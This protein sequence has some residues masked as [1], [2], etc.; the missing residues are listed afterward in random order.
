MT[1]PTPLR[2]RLR[3]PVEPFPHQ[4]EALAVSWRKRAFGLLMDPGLGKT[5]VILDTVSLLYDGGHIRG[6]F[7]LAP[8]DVQDQWVREQIP[9]HLSKHIL[10][11]CLVWDA[12][13]HVP[14]MERE[15]K[16]ICTP[17]AG[18]LHVFAMN[19][20]ALSTKRGYN[21][22]KRF[23][24]AHPSMFALDES[25]EFRTP[26]NKRTRMLGWLEDY[27]F[28]KRIMTGTLSGGTPWPLYS[29][30][31][32]LDKRILQCD[33]YLAFKHRYA[34]WADNVS[35]SK[36]V[37]KKTGKR[38]IVHYE[39]LMEYKQLEELNQRIAP[40]VYSKKKED[41][42]GL[43]PKLYE[44]VPT[45]LS[46]PQ[47]EVY[48]GLFE[49]GLVLLDRHQ[50]GQAINPAKLEQLE[51]TDLLER[52]QSPT[53]RMSYR[54]KLT[55]WLR[56]QQATAGIVKDDAGNISVIDGNWLCNPRMR[57][58][59]RWVEQALTANSGR[60]KVIVWAHYRPVLEAL[61]QCLHPLAPH[62]L[63]HGGTTGAK[64]AERIARFKDPNSDTRILIAHPRTLGTGQNFDVASYVLYYTRSFSF[65]QRKQSEDRAHRL[66]SKGTVTI[67]DLVA[68]DSGTDAKEIQAIRDKADIV[69][70]LETFDMRN[71]LKC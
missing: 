3:T 64:R 58:T 41:C 31:N 36:Q 71:L 30:F 43:P 50:L 51:E 68:H 9:I 45:Q 4:W 12:G 27:A 29:Q 62:I 1:T 34:E 17:V 57:A 65:F 6:L 28:A 16:A 49:Q 38:K 63:I 13:V 18:R 54:I 15:V 48:K 24:R 40:F 55:M 60:A 11:R 46:P 7:V 44:T 14:K 37:D 32:F 69:Q 42:D 67:G 53:D 33:S 26:S 56:L 19:H 8:N 59:M 5:K 20:E 21:A 66:S 22:A 39:V 2:A 52:V 25:H 47:V 35:V 10:T 70:Q 23:L 61:Q